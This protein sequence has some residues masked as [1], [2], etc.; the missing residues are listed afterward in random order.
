MPSSHT[1]VVCALATA[2]A[3]TQGLNSATFAIT[4]ILAIVV[5]YDAT[6]VRQAVSQQSTILNRIVKELMDKRPRSEVERDLREFVGHTP[7]QVIAG[8]MLGIFIAWLWLAERIPSVVKWALAVGFCGVL[9]I[10]RPEAGDISP[11]A[12]I[13]LA[14]GVLAAVAKVTVRR[15]AVTEPASRIVFYFA[16]HAA[17]LSAVPLIWAW[18][19]PSDPTTWLWLASVG[20]LATAGQFLLTRGYALK[21]AG[22][23]AP[24]SYFSLLFGALLGWIFWQ[25]AL[26]W[27]ILIG[28][29]LI[30][31]GGLLASRARHEPAGAA[32]LEPAVDT[33][34]SR[35]L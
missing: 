4:A 2:V 32:H 35:V 15:L 24:F 25:E 7:F 29:S 16:L 19:M 5:M 20:A 14:G 9:I 33:R 23:L 28:A 1:A 26:T 3:M 30:V 27:G 11:V 8:A 6:G 13:A 31:V 21:P 12:V 17:L 10:L 22:Q 18:E 34:P